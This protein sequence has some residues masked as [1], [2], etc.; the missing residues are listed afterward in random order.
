MRLAVRIQPGA[1]RAGVRGRRPDGALQIAVTAPA[2]G[3]RANRALLELVS[4]LLRLRP[5]QVRLARGAAARSKTLAIEGITAEEL[6]RR[7][8]RAVSEAEAKHGG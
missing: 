4:D 7:V 5:A 6:E 2:E 3:G 8:A 1:R